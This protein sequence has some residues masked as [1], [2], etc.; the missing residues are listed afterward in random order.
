MA[1]E[2]RRTG[3]PMLQCDQFVELVQLRALVDPSPHQR[4]SGVHE[5][6]PGQGTGS[7][8]GVGGHARN[9]TNH[10]TRVDSQ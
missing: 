10:A 1:G 2:S 7:A 6:L 8:P 9:A 4:P 5:R 3:K